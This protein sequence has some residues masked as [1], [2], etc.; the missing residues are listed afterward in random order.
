MTSF[1]V[2]LLLSI[3]PG[4]VTDPPASD[5]RKIEHAGLDRTF[6][7]HLPKGRNDDK[8]VPLVIVLHGAGANGRITELLTGF[9]PLADRH[10]FAAVYP[11]AEPGGGLGVW[12]F[13]SAGGE[14]TAGAA[15]KAKAKL[16]ARD[17]FG[18]I[19]ALIDQ[20]VAE[21]VADARRVYVTGISNG[22]FMTNRLACVMPER[23]AAIA[24]V[25]GTMVKWTAQDTKPSRPMPV[26][27]MHG[28]DDKLMGLSGADFLSK[29]ELSLSAADL[30]AWWAKHNGC[31]GP[32]RVEQLPDTAADGTT[33]ER[34][35]FEP[36]GGAAPV[37]YYEISGGGHTWPGG[38]VQP[39]ALLGKTSRDIDA[40]TI[41]WEFFSRHSLP[42]PTKRQVGE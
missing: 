30:V 15:K 19:A 18:F 21:R 22:A 17:D 12:Q 37:I 24:P 27:Y 3:L 35:T 9:S 4:S 16:V 7:L 31:T 2:A 23:I 42:T 38:S 41:I 26:L 29:R 6:L 40:S 5:A 14:Q 20:L 28:T 33:V 11:D 25:A 8:P 10:G 36:R 39:E 34:R 32:P 1:C 13:W